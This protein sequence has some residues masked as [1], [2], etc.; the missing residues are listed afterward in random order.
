[1]TAK[2]KFLRQANH[3]DIHHLKYAGLITLEV[4]VQIQV[5][6]YG[7]QISDYPEHVET[8][9]IL[10]QEPGLSFEIDESRNTGQCMEL[11]LLFMEVA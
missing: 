11:N 5:K 10:P 7:G 6:H 9:L 1:M 3:S 4:P 2:G 8:F